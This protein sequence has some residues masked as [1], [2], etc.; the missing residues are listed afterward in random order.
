MA[1]I[2]AF[3]RES[4]RER[5]TGLLFPASAARLRQ[6]AV[7]YPEQ[8]DPSRRVIEIA[9]G[10]TAAPLARLRLILSDLETGVS[11]GPTAFEVAVPAGARAL[12]LDDLRRMSPSRRHRPPRSDHAHRHAAGVCQD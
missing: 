12:T 9:V 11:L 2:L 6:V 10:P 1:G 7:V 4:P 3:A 8:A 5:L